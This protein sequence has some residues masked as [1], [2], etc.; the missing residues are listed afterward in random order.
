MFAEEV[1]K[2]RNANK[3]VSYEVV[4]FNFIFKIIICYNSYEI[5]QLFKGF[6]DA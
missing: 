5:Y 6:F 3:C 2:E 1:E 4:L